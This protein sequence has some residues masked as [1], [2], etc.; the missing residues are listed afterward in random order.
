MKSAKEKGRKRE[1]EKLSC[2]DMCVMKFYLY[3]RQ[4]VR[5]LIHTNVYIYVYRDERTH[6]RSKKKKEK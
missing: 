3:V 2:I 1:K 6:L 5:T 4:T